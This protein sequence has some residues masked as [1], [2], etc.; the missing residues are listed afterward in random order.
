MSQ[1]IINIGAVAND[2]TGDQLRTAF[3]KANSNFTEL[4]GGAGGG[5]GMPVLINGNFQLWQRGTSFT[6]DGYTADRWRLTEGAGNTVTLTRQ[7][8]ALDTLAENPVYHLRLDRTV[9]ASDSVL[10]QRVESVYTGS[11]QTVTFSFWA[12]ASSAV[13][14]QASTTQNFGTGGSPSSPVDSSLQSVAVTTSWVRYSVQ[15]PLA[16]ISGK[17]L[18][19]GLNDY[20]S[21]KLTVP[22]AAGN[23]TVDLA[24]AQ[25]DLS[26]SAKAFVVVPLDIDLLRAQRYYEIFGAGTVGRWS[27]A[28]QAVTNASFRTTKR[29]VP[30]TVTVITQTWEGA[31][32][33][34]AGVSGSSFASSAA[35]TVTING[36]A[37]VVTVNSIGAS[38]GEMCFFYTN[39]TA[40][41]AEL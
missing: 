40:A 29:G 23:V 38:A 12:K 25:V 21:F 15:I 34:I 1:Q 27:S 39:N 19:T 10:E 35:G 37:A 18:G 41:E 33:G 11:N 16:S 2:H 26:A 28:T 6:A 13:T 32:V 8:L 14:L 9:T 17:T 5:G 31:R 30:V 36:Y 20:V 24:Q 4:Y 3:N 22:S 7:A